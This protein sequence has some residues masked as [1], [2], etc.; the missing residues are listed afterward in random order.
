VAE[1]DPESLRIRSFNRRF[2]RLSGR[3]R[4]ELL[5]LALDDLVTSEGG[6]AR[7]FDLS[8]AAHTCDPVLVTIRPT[9]G[10]FDPVQPELE[11]TMQ[12]GV[13]GE[14]S[15]RQ[16]IVVLRD[17][18]ADLR[19]LAEREQL[20]ATIAQLESKAAEH[21]CAAAPAS[22]FAAPEPAPAARRRVETQESLDDLIMRESAWVAEQRAADGSVAHE[23]SVEAVAHDLRVPLTSI[24]SFSEILLDHS[25][26]ASEERAEF[27]QIIRSESQRL[28]RMV[29]DLLDVRRV[30]SGASELALSDMDLRDLVRDALNSLNGLAIERG[31]T[32]EGTWARVER[33]VRGDRDQLHRMVANLLSNAVKF[34]PEHGIVEIILRDGDSEGCTRLGVRDHGPG[35]S[36]ED[37]ELV[38]ERFSRGATGSEN[39]SGTGLGLSICRE[40]VEV[41]GAR[42]WPESRPQS[43]ATLWVEFPAPETVRAA[44]GADLVASVGPA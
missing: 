7:S 28:G 38:F 21:V 24:R 1:L 11:V 29:D 6:V 30:K 18:T 16:L 8:L 42:I 35:I 20:I 15:E 9:T 36:D 31:I 44:P 25:D 32:F 2:E 22:P 5:G 10:P 34:S 37:Q 19:R 39:V 3:S 13:A 40:I 41:H 4:D 43:G 33:T 17:A 26:V 14:P 23:R 27:L 12:I